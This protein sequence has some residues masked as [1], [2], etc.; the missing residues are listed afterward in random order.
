MYVCVLLEAGAGG[1]CLAA[2]GTGVTA[3]AHVVGADV[4]LQVAR[5]REHLLAVLA[6][7]TTKLAVDHLV[8][9]KKSILS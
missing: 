5:V 4:T 2:L 7:E 3:S 6:G 8:P 1:E 9:E